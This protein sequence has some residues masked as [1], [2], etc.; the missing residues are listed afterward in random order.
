MQRNNASIADYQEF[1]RQEEIA[2]RKEDLA[3][4]YAAK[5]KEVKL[6][7]FN[8][9]KNADIIQ[10]TINTALAVTKVAPNPV[11]MALAAASG[12]VNIGF[13]AS[14]P[15]PVFAKGGILNGPSHAEGGIATAFGEMEG[16]EAVIN[17]KNTALFAPILSQINSY[18]GNGVSFA[19]T[20]SVSSQPSLNQ[21]NNNLNDVKNLLIE[22][23]SRPIMTYVNESDVTKAQRNKQKIVGRATF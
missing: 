7:A 3:A 11:L 16:G 6:K 2:K 15:D 12:A 4:S 14:Q 22:F 13:I 1:T 10:A 9:Q 20:M 17:K 5:E 23:T 8:N 19:P 18:G 21:Q